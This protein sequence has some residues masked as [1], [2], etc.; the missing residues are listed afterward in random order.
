MIRCRLGVLFFDLMITDHLLLLLLLLLSL[1]LLLL[2]SSSSLLLL[3]LLLLLLFS[4]LVGIGRI[5]ENVL[6]L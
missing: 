2:S 6:Y 1:A 5:L 4:V 3:L